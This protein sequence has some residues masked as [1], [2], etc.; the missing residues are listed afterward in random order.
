MHSFSSSSS[1]TAC[2]LFTLLSQFALARTSQNYS[3]TSPVLLLA[4]GACFGLLYLV[5]SRAQQG[6]LQAR[7]SNCAGNCCKWHRTAVQIAGR[8]LPPAYQYA[9][10]A[11]LSFPLFY[12]A[13][14]G[15]V[16]FWVI[17]ASIVAILLHA[18]L[19]ASEPQPGQ[20]FETDIETV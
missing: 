11:L 7:I 14:A 19:Y 4:L 18:L 16:I 3:L 5:R 20:E 9:L 2:S 8:T 17:G 1:S 10:V 6:Q 15:S 13:G 12:M